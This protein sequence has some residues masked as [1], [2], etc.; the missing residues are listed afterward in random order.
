[1]KSQPVKKLIFYQRSRRGAAAKQWNYRQARPPGSQGVG[2]EGQGR[3]FCPRGGYASIHTHE[4]HVSHLDPEQ[5]AGEN[6]GQM[7]SSLRTQQAC[8]RE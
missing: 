5:I 1:M 7:L 6:G 2:G 8:R 4:A 3:Y